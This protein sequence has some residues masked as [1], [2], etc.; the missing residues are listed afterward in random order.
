MIY[1]LGRPAYSCL[2]VQ[3]TALSQAGVTILEHIIN[4]EAGEA[5]GHGVPASELHQTSGGGHE[6]LT[7]AGRV[8]WPGAACHIGACHVTTRGP[9]H[10]TPGV[11]NYLR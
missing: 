1:L 8:A 4:V 5:G 3:G 10:V 11:N 6:H 2:G 7:G 9:G